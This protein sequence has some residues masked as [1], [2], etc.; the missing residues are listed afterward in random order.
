MR[1]DEGGDHGER[2]NPSLSALRDRFDDPGCGGRTDSLAGDSAR[3]LMTQGLRFLPI[4]EMAVAPATYARSVP[5][6]RQEGLFHRCREV[7]R[8]TCTPEER[9]SAGSCPLNSRSA[10]A[11]SCFPAEISPGP[12]I[13]TP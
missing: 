5:A 6:K 9:V 13:Q 2:G 4:D 10:P 12:S 11:P 8:F 1:G 3:Y 7:R